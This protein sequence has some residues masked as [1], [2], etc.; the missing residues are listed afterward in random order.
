MARPSDYTLE[1]AMTICERLVEGESLRAIC[2]EDAMPGLS[3]VF[4]WLESH[5][6]FRE[7]Y[8]R[9]REMQAEGFADELTEIADDARNDWME[10]ALKGGETEKVIDSEHIT[11]SRLRV[12]TRKWIASKLLPKKYGDKLETTH[13]GPGGGPIVI[14]NTD[15]EL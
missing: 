3:T 1:I 7:Q 15:A 2:R 10:R 8:A 11:R 5:E 9:A 13:Q 4:R 6:P 14:S 12:D